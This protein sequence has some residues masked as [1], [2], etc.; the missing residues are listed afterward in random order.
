MKRNLISE[1]ISWKNKK[2]RKPLIIKGARQ[3][4]KTYLLEAFGKEFFPDYH[5]INF[6]KD[7]KLSLIFE[8]DLN[9]KRIIQELC[10]KIDKDINI[11][12][13]LLIFDEIQNCPKAL[14]SLK[15]FSEDLGGLAICAAGSLLGI[16]F[17]H[18]SFPVGK[19][20]FLQLFPMSFEEFLDGTGDVK[21]TTFLK[22]FKHDISIPEVVHLHLWNQ[23]KIYFIVGGLPEAVKTYDQRKE[24]LF[25][26]LKHVRKKQE[27]LITTYHA[28]MAKHS[29]KQ[30]AMR[31]ERLWKNIPAQLA[32]EQ[33]SK[34]AK[35]KFNN[36]IPGINR[37]SQ[38][39]GI[40]DWL[41]SAGLII[42]THI[43][44]K[45]E[46]PFSAYIKENFFKLYL[47]DIGML[48]ALS[49]LPPKSILEYDYG[50]Y[51][52]YFAENFV[53]QEFISSGVKDLYSW[54]EKTAEVEFLREYDSIVLPV[55]VKSGWV[56][57]SKSLKVFSEKYTPPFRTIM[58]ANKL[59]FDSKNKI[60]RYPLYLAYRFPVK[61]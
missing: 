26:A 34:A 38:L 39:V 47:F 37:F 45:G 41:K 8:Y 2:D 23:L 15:Y 16:Q 7:E 19:V 56:T 48:G 43:V 53:A 59:H 1:L 30:N 54:K 18:N 50:S 20:D 21:S 57:Q 27:D 24:N 12:K 52:G 36:V 32:R 44:N 35:F 11:E 49:Q 46:L 33:N 9:P 13:D 28:D 6:E 10:F 60:H 4:G 31:L 58:S 5:I 61:I 3:V 40:I 17:S 42:Q 25:D 29:G 22:N 14:T 51:K 55:E